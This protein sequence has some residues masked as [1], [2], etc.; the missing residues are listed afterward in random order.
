MFTVAIISETR[1]TIF[2]SM[3]VRHSR[4]G[5]RYPSVAKHAQN[6]FRKSDLEQR[7]GMEEY[8]AFNLSQNPIC[9][10]K[11]LVSHHE[12]AQYVEAI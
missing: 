6:G 3:A 9:F 1:L 7:G 8:Y 11:N 12:L 2:H 4:M 5:K 10:I